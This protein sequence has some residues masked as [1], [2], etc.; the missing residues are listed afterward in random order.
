MP[1]HSLLLNL[2]DRLQE[3]KQEVVDMAKTLP[4]KKRHFPRRRTMD[5]VPSDI[6]GTPE[7]NEDF[8]DIC[9]GKLEGGGTIP[10]S[11]R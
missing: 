3:L 5:R 9:K 10:A 4:P 1:T 6:E 7:L 2:I 11:F 8:G